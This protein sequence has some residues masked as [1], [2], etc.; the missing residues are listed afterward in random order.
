L[1]ERGSIAIVIELYEKE[2]PF[3][4]I[5]QSTTDD[6]LIKILCACKKFSDCLRNVVRWIVSLGFDDEQAS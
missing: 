4:T 1:H 3:T 5:G 6:L 2:D